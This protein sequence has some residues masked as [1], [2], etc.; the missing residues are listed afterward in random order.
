MEE[1]LGGI[2]PLSSC[3]IDELKNA[4]HILATIIALKKGRCAEEETL[5]LQIRIE[6]VRRK[7]ESNEN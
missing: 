2:Y 7:D 3:P 5:L 6:L 4:A 1:F